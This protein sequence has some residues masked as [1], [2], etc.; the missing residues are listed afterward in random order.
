[1]QIEFSEKQWEYLGYLIW[2]PTCIASNRIHIL[3]VYMRWLHNI[4]FQEFPAATLSTKILN[5]SSSEFASCQDLF[6]HLMCSE[7]LLPCVSL[8]VL[9]ISPENQVF[10][11]LVLHNRHSLVPLFH[12]KECLECH[13]FALNKC[14]SERVC[15]FSWHFLDEV[16]GVALR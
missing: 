5:Q 12:S 13:V 15:R 16:L 10:A 3:D 8:T 2:F 9:K 14:C 6:L 11:S 4:I 1:M 7:I